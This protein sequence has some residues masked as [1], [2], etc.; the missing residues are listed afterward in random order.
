MLLIFTVAAT[1]GAT[2]TFSTDRVITDAELIAFSQ[3]RFSKADMM[4]QHLAL[5]MHNGL[6]VV[7]DHP[8]GDICPSYTLRIIHYQLANG[9]AC[10]EVGG[11]VLR[12]GVPRAIAV[13]LESFCVPK[14]LG[15]AALSLGE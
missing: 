13:N 7:A 3:E 4:F 11:V 2:P 9:A 5:G 8:C 12:V 6:Q 14:V 10:E 1:L 15:L